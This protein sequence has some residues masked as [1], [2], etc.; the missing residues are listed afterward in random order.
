MREMTVNQ[1]REN[2]RKSV[3]TAI[4]NHEPLRITRRGKDDFVVLGAE[5]W[6]SEQETLYVLQ[7]KSL[8]SQIKESAQTHLSGTG[9][10]PNQED[11]DEIDSI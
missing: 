6:E 9:Y 5:D 11:L 7:N 8:M 4:V 1:F 3:D 10:K 2:L